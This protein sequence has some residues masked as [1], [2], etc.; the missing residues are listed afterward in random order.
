MVGRDEGVFLTV[1]L[2][3]TTTV[4]GIEDDVLDLEAVPF[5]D[6]ELELCTQTQSIPFCTRISFGNEQRTHGR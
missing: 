1:E 6:P 5:G 3:G 4:K 2:A